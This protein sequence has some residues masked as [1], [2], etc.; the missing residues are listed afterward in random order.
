VGDAIIRVKLSPQQQC[1]IL[2]FSLQ[3]I[4]KCRKLESMHYHYFLILLA[5]KFG[6]VLF[7]DPRFFEKLSFI[8]LSYILA[9]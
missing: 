7:E 3:D 6:G 9:Q 4:L 1:S 8:G 5:A 2:T